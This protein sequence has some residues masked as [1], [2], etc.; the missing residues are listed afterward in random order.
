[1]KKILSLAV[2][3]IASV[4]MFAQVSIVPKVGLN[5]ANTTAG[6]G[7]SRT[8]LV[9]GAEVMIP[10]AESVGITLGALYSSQGAKGSKLDYLNVP[11]LAHYY[12]MPG[13][14][15]KSGVQC[16]FLLSSDVDKEYLNSFDLSI[17][18]GVSY[19]FGKVIVDARY[20]IGVTG[21]E[22]SKYEDALGKSK[23][24]VIQFTV[25]YKF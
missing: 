17:P 20:N 15:I 9:A 8:A 6:G 11:V 21:I 2:A 23:N 24:D 22:A 18:V 5:I 16:G 19:E 25:G 7:D 13:L 14:A 1:M 12:L 4:S 10:T 3:L